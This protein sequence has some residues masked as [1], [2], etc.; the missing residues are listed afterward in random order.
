M[1]MGERNRGGMYGV[2]GVKYNGKGVG[3]IWEEGVEGGGEWGWKRGMWGGEKGK[4]GL[5]VV[6]WR[7]G[8]KRWRLRVMEVWGEKMIEVMGGRKERRGVYVGG[9]EEKEVEGVLEMERVRG[10]RMGMYKGVVRWNLGK[11]MKLRNVVGMEWE[12]EMEDGG[13]KGG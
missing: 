6:K 5:G 13:E 4:G 3:V 1:I 10:E 11:G 8:R 12:V 7:G 9:R 2:K